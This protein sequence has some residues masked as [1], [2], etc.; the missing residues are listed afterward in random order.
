MKITFFDLEGWEKLFLQ[1]KLKEH[2]LNFIEDKLDQDY[3]PNKKNV[4]VISVFISS[5]IN[6]Q[7]LQNFPNLKLIVTR[8]T[9]FDHIDL[10]ASRRKNILVANVPTYGANTVAEHSFALILDLSR[11][12]YESYDRLRRSGSFSLE[13]LRGFDLKGKTLGVVG[14]GNIGHH[15]IRMAKG[16]QMKVIA[17]DPAPNKIFAQ[18]MGFSY[19]DNLEDVL[20]NSDIV[21]LHAP[22]NEQ[23]KHLINQENINKIRKGAYIVNTARGGLIETEALVKSLQEGHLAGAALDVLEE[24][25]AVKEELELLVSGRVDKHNIKTMLQNHALIN[26]PNVIIT[27]HNAFNSREALQRILKT[28]V[29]NIKGFISGRPINIVNS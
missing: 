26:M 4:E 12:I 6:S 23:T 29:E 28:T 7:V 10:K 15:V 22:L 18:E 24:E 8:S 21:T 20:A 3:I 1:K 16:F 5:Q 19:R 11:K 25:G 13:G 14:T 17:Y 2:E 9:G 27:P